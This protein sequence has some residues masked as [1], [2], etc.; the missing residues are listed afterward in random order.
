MSEITR[1]ITLNIYEPESSLKMYKNMKKKSIITKIIK[2]PDIMPD[3]KRIKE[4]FTKINQNSN[5][6]NDYNIFF[7]PGEKIFLQMKK[8]GHGQD[9]QKD[10]IIKKASKIDKS[11]KGHKNKK[12]LIN[13]KQLEKINKNIPNNLYD[14][15]HPYEYRYNL[16]KN[17]LLK[18]FLEMQINKIKDD[19]KENNKEI[20]IL[21]LEEDDTNQ[22]YNIIN[23][24]SSNLILPLKNYLKTTSNKKPSIISK[25]LK[26]SKTMNNEIYI[27]GDN[28][29][30]NNKINKDDKIIRLKTSKERDDY[31]YSDED[32]SSLSFTEKINNNEKIFETNIK[33]KLYINGDEIDNYKNLLNFNTVSSKI[34]NSK[35]DPSTQRSANTVR[36]NQKVF[37]RNNNIFT[38]YE[39]LKKLVLHSDCERT[40]RSLKKNY[41]LFQYTR[42]NNQNCISNRNSKKKNKK[43]KLNK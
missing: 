8:N 26:I 39:D 11:F 30:N 9:E 36:Y 4:K 19:K 33:K 6:L 38:P 32:S 35:K 15:L 14:Y 5:H 20:K 22:N 27:K 28:K 17:N 16:K 18:N 13:R 31:Y 12:F 2:N 10:D 37:N 23:Y 25:S 3:K 1:N 34:T 24:K 7:R 43:I 41:N 42:N 29:N 21:N 40:K